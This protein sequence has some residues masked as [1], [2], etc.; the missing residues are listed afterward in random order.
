MRPDRTTLLEW[1]KP[2]SYAEKELD[3]VNL[4]KPGDYEMYNEKLN[5][6]LAEA[7]EIFI[8]MGITSMLH[9]GDLIVGI[10]TREGDMATCSAG[11]Y[12]HSVSAQLPVKFI[13][14]NWIDNPTVGVRNGDIFYA[15]EASYGGIHNPDQIAIMPVFNDDELIAWVIAAVHQPET[16]GTE[17]G[18]MVINAKSLCDEGMRLTPIKIGENFRLRDDLLEMMENMVVRTPRMQMIDVRA[19]ATSCDRLRRRIVDLAKQKGNGFVKG[20]LY[21]LVIEAERAARRRISAWND[22]VYRSMVLV[23]TQGIDVGLLRVFCTMRKKNDRITFDFTG[24]SPEHDGGAYHGLPHHVLAHIAVY[25]FAFAFHDLPVSSGA[26][27][28]IDL[29]VPEGCFYNP[30][31]KAP[32]SCTPP[33]CLP[34]LGP[35]YILFAKMIFDSEQRIEVSAPQADGVYTVIAGLNQWGVPVAD[36]TAYGFNTEGQGARLDMDGVDAYGF[37]L[38]HVGRAPDAEYVEN[39]FP[40]FHLFQK[41]HKDS[42]GY[43]KYRGGAS[44]TSAHVIHH[45]SWAIMH[46]NSVNFNTTSNLGLFGGYPGASRP[47]IQVTNTDLWE[48][49]ARG[50]KDLP[51]DLIQLITQKPI[52]GEYTVEP[53]QRLGRPLNNGDIFC[54]LSHG[55]AGYGDVLERAPEMVMEDIRQEIISHKT[56]QNVYH[57]AYD[58]VTLEVDYKKT[59]ELRQREF[60]SRK[61][62][63]K[64][65][66]DFTKEWLQKRPPEEA[67][68]HWGRWPDAAKVRTIHRV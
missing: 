36:L 35:T 26:L 29:V 44:T 33:A 64:K 32:L 68:K 39:E 11:T 41:L 51:S 57:V 46:C 21:K 40:L 58:P 49:M 14:N 1:V 8:R 5:N 2:S 65:Y 18:G 66:E 20:L 3:Y 47:G 50:D 12:L 10:Y 54:D 52:R 24:T 60:E 37:S 15:S 13:V 63:G 31:D 62:R 16:G 22:G 43:G 30:D 19:R 59:E 45:V 67:L 55:G 61:A 48:K 25:L 56:A 9:S 23:D 4:L 38:C 27:A 34:V 7:K 6:I 53:L 17:P 28:P 42:C